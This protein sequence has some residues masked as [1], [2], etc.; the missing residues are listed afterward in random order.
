MRSLLSGL[1]LATFL[2]GGCERRSPVTFGAANSLIV[3]APER[4]W[5]AVRD[6]VMSA[7]EPTIRTVREERTFEVTHVSPLDTAWLELRKF[8][9][10]I[11]L[12]YEGDSWLAPAM[13]GIDSVPEQLPAII[14]VGE[15]WAREQ[16]VTAVLLPG[17]AGREAVAEIVP[18]LHALLDERYRTYVRGRMFTSGVDEGLR[19]ELLRTAGFGL[20][21]PDVYRHE[22]PGG[23][24]HVFR[25]H[26][27]QGS[28][29][30]RRGITIDW[31]P[32]ADSISP[33][34]LMRWRNSATTAFG[35]EQEVAPEAPDVRRLTGPGAGALEVRGAWQTPAGDWPAAGPFISR[36]VRCPK[37]N[38]MYLMDAW[39]YAPTESKY[40]Y[41]IQFETILNSFTCGDDQ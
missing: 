9:Q 4:L 16:A 1:L 30:L 28:K 14:E 2:L 15:V 37:Q 39:L 10:V 24:Q 23:T 40:E 7:L 5:E 34:E 12:G 22:Q 3:V 25:N 19:R 8:R 17:G 18:E 26:Y 13:G 36:A 31:R 35:F 20:T 6:T 33:R 29:E 11:L 41:V 27:A 21:L 32:L 38:R